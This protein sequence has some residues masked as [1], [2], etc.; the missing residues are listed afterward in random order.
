MEWGTGDAPGWGC[1]MQRDALEKAAGAAPGRP[2]QGV[3]RD[4]DG[5][6]QRRR[7]GGG[8]ACA[9]EVGTG[10]AG[11]CGRAGHWAGHW[12]GW[13]TGGGDGAGAGLDPPPGE[14]G[15]PVKGPG[16]L[17]WGHGPTALG[18]C[19]VARVG[20]PR[21]WGSCGRGWSCPGCAGRGTPQGCPFPGLGPAQALG[22][23]EGGVALPSPP[24]PSACSMWGGLRQGRGS[25]AAGD[26]R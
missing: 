1:G 21:I 15:V 8:A 23:C 7:W 2:G 17:Q 5:G 3:G 19:D 4:G 25:Q 9:G 13:G 22:G 16:G 14:V 20:S 24:P 12:A 18:W 10:R 26:T 6:M 11:L